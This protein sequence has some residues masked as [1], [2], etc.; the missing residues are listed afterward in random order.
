MDRNQDIISPSFISARSVIPFCLGN[1][2]NPAVR[3]SMLS[4]IPGVNREAF[5]LKLCRTSLKR[6]RNLKWAVETVRQGNP[7]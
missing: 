4:R 5:F 2:A 7:V 3:R 1:A 6:I